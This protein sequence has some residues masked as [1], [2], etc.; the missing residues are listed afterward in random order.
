MHQL[1]VVG[2]V[3]KSLEVLVRKKQR[4]Q[5]RLFD[6][7]LARD[8]CAD[9]VDRCIEVVES[10]HHLVNGVVANDLLADLLN[11]IVKD[12]DVVAV[13]ADG[14]GY[15]QGYLIVEGEKRGNLVG[16]DLGGMIVTGI[17]QA[18]DVGLC[19]IVLIEFV[20]ANGVAFHTDTEDLAFHSDDDPLAIVIGEDLVQGLLQTGARA[21]TVGGNI[22]ETVGDPDVDKALGAHRTAELGS[23][24]KG[25]LT[26]IDPEG[27]DLLIGRGQA[28]TVLHHGMSKEGGVEVDADDT[29]LLG[30]LDPGLKVLIGIRIAVH[31]ALILT[32]DGIASVQVELLGTGHEGEGLFDICHQLLGTYG[33]TG[34]VTRR[35]NTARQRVGSVEADNVVAL[36][37]MDADG[38]VLQRVERRLG[39]YTVGC[40]H[41]FC[42]IVS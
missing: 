37:A 20:A 23:N 26:V 39:I 22:L 7:A 34:I 2:A 11:L 28:E 25:C 3:L 8:P 30:K 10:D 36:P 42:F 21:K 31:L 12:D 5:Q 14:T 38:N 4:V 9:T 32:E 24:T 27:T 33:T 13:P 18:A 17:Q 16:N 29:V 40:I 41:L 6:R 1:A 35:L 19:G 15:V